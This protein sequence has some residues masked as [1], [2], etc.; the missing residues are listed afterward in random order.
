MTNHTLMM[1]VIKFVLYH[2]KLLKF[3]ENSLENRFHT[4]PTRCVNNALEL[5]ECRKLDRSQSLQAPRFLFSNR[6][7]KQA[8]KVERQQ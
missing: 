2:H 7:Y 5:C 3:Q 8:Q 1:Q 4:K 6:I